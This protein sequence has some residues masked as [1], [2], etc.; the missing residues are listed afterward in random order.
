MRFA[1]LKD[2]LFLFCVAAY[3]VNRLVFKRIW[4]DGFVHA[5][6]NDLICIPFWVP[7]MLFGMRQLGLRRDDSPPAAHEIIIPLLLWS[8]LFEIILPLDPF[9]SAYT[10]ADPMDVFWYCV[11]AFVA[12]V[13]WKRRYGAVVGPKL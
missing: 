9:W 13:F 10:V 5:H 11:G 4:P 7:I 6:F 12:G 2:P 1:Y 3:F 8:V